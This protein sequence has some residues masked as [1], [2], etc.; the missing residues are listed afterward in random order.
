MPSLNQVKL[1][2]FHTIHLLTSLLK[3]M[4]SKTRFLILL[5]LAIVTKR[6][7]NLILK[8][9]FKLHRRGGISL[10]LIKA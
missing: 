4:N 8:A 3:L 5:I 9:G 6:N 7:Q 1:S 10:I 2:L